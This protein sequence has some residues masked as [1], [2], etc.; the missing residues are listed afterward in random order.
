MSVGIIA[1]CVFQAR[2]SF[3]VRQWQRSERKYIR[4]VQVGDGSSHTM[5]LEKYTAYTDCLSD[6]GRCRY[7]FGILVLLP[8]LPRLVEAGLALLLARPCVPARQFPSGAGR[9]LDALGK[10]R[11]L[12]RSLRHLAGSLG[13]PH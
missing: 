6:T 12:A 5:V 10:V 4:I 13:V 9:D 7:I 2:W 8:K 3:T 1:R 11:T